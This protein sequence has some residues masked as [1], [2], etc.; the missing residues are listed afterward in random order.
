MQT[1]GGTDEGGGREEGREEK[2]ERKRERK[3]DGSRHGGQFS[4]TCTGNPSP[5]PPV[6]S[7]PLRASSSRTSLPLSPSS[8]PFIGLEKKKG[9]ALEVAR[10]KKK[11]VAIASKLYNFSVKSNYVILTNFIPP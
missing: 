11:I 8:L 4:G 6:F 3:R 2:K 9:N 1:G 7:S 5:S 10:K